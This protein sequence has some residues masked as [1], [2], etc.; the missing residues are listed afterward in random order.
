[1][2]GTF[3]AIG[4]QS[5][6]VCCQQWIVEPQSKQYLTG[7]SPA[8]PSSTKVSSQNGQYL[9]TYGF[10][11]RYYSRN[12]LY[13]LLLVPMATAN[14]SL[15]LTMGVSPNR[16]ALGSRTSIFEYP[17]F[18]KTSLKPRY[19]GLSFSSTAMANRTT[20][21]PSRIRKRPAKF[22]PGLTANKLS[23]YLG[24][25]PTSSSEPTDRLHLPEPISKPL[26]S[27]NSRKGRDKQSK[28]TVIVPMANSATSAAITGR[29]R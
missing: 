16:R 26:S 13:C 10:T 6:P 20:A 12:K 9:G 17:Q 21:R 22:S 15:S 5:F 29:N 8:S 19:L 2:P 11:G 23:T 7:G 3:I 28:V 24:N 27:Q 25:Q 4:I 18:L 1:M 14:W